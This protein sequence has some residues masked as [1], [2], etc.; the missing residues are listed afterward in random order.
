MPRQ[1]KPGRDFSAL[2]ETQ[3]A[4]AAGI[5]DGEGCIVIS[6]DKNAKHVGGIGYYLALQVLT[7]DGLLPNYL[8][9]LF[10]GN[11]RKSTDP[12][13]FADRECWYAVS[14]HAAAVLELVLPYLLVKKDQALLAMEFRKTVGRPG[15]GA[16]TDEIRQQRREQYEN[17]RALKRKRP[18]HV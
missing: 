17:M 16:L 10:G 1:W 7:T 5:I 6:R 12:R 9:G 15:P 8:K 13:G 18:T 3:I 11:I 2:T 4:Y 14:A